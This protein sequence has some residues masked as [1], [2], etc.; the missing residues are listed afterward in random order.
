MKKYSILVIFLISL[1]LAGQDKLA[2][3][4][5][6]NKRDNTAV[7]NAKITE[8]RTGSSTI[9]DSAGFFEFYVPKKTRSIMV[10]HDDYKPLHYGLH[11][12]KSTK[13]L[14]LKVNPYHFEDPYTEWATYKNAIMLSPSELINGAVAVRYE[15]FIK[16]KH[17]IGIH[18]SFYLFGYNSF[19]LDFGYYPANFTGI[20]LTPFYRYYPV[21]AHRYGLF[22]EGKFSYGY[23]DFSTLTYGY[24]NYYRKNL[25]ETFSTVG[26]AIAVGWMFRLPKTKHGIANL[27]LGVQ[28]FPFTG[29][30]SKLAPRSDGEMVVWTTNPYWWYVWSPGAVFEVKFTIGGFF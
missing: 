6:I 30:T 17:A 21:R 1:H 4:Y 7:P 23:F 24:A 19:L 14:L 29:N 16:K 9:T 22:L 28:T 8:T 13:K 27:S 12:H 5:I 2:R 15:R 25:P 10:T 26:A 20:K 11:P 3:G 18:T